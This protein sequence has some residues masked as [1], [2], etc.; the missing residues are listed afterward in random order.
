MPSPQHAAQ[1]DAAIGRFHGG[2]FAG[3]T[4]RI[5]EGWFCEL[6][7]NALWISA[8]YE[9]LRGW[10]PG[11]KGEFAHEPYHGY[12]PLD[13]TAVESRL[14]SEEDFRA[15]VD[16]A[17]AC[18]LRV[19][20]DVVMG[21]AG[22]P[23]LHSL[24]ECA[25]AALRPGWEAA[26][27]DT[28][29]AFCELDAQRL[30]GWW[31]PDWVRFEAPGYRPGGDDD[32]TRL[33]YG[34]P[35]FLTEDDTPVRLPGFLRDRPGS[36]AR[37][38]EA[39]PVRGYLLQWLGDWVRRY[40]VDGFRCDSV[41]HVDKR[42][43]RELKQHAELALREWRS[44][45]GENGSDAGFWMTG[46]VYG[47]GAA[48]SD[49][50]EYG[51][52]SL[53]NFQFQNEIDALF[54]HVDLDHALSRSL[55]WH[56]L[57]KLYARYALL[58]ADGVTD[59]LSYLSSHDTYLFD[60]GK[61]RYG[62]IALLLAPGGVQLFY[63]DES[64]RR[65]G[66]YTPS[67]PCQATRSPMNWDTVDADLLQHWRKLG[68]F[69]ARHVALA[70]G[71]HRRLGMEPYVFARHDAVSGDRIVVVLGSGAVRVAVEELFAE[72]QVLHD[73]YSGRHAV[74]CDGHVDLS[75][76]DVALLESASAGQRSEP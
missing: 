52:D 68:R 55:V 30:Q 25:P 8:P 43:W 16:A 51:F 17:H 27:P 60:R 9:Q 74:V 20:L 40:G 56:R 14:G 31:G 66:P 57:D 70:R 39:T 37:D 22:Y 61:L 41:K 5:R 49:Y 69:R 54:Q 67:D 10:I 64:G 21:H 29:D 48:P 28:F 59:T 58:L 38:L 13:F 62:A 26:T 15:L 1:G 42:C 36:R 6:G 50:F 72:G 71:T 3:V 76:C 45:R 35:K 12:W 7:V 75:I 19:V 47:H 63:G 2:G 32:L 53:I 44:A 33:S 18:G 65:P 23:D 4:Q 46:E 34:L 11:A 24:Q 73:A